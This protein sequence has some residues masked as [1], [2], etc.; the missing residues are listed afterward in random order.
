M[1]KSTFFVLISV[2]LLTLFPQMSIATPNNHTPYELKAM[3]INP[4]E[5]HPYGSA[6]LT[7]KIEGLPRGG[8][9]EYWYVVIEKKIKA[10]GEWK[11]SDE[12][13]SHMMLD[14]YQTSAG[15][16]EFE[17]IW[18]EDYAWDA[19]TPVSFRVKVALYDETYSLISE[20][21]YSNVASIGLQGSGW[22]MPELEKAN[23]YGLIPDILQGTDMTKPITREEFCELALL[24][25]E[26]STGKTPVPVSPNPFTDTQNP[27]I[28]KAF[29]L[30]ITQGTSKTT[31]SPDNTITRQECATML[32]RTI[33]AIAPNADYSVTGVPDFPD[34]KEI[35]SWAIEG[36]KYMSKLGIIK[37]DDRGYFMPKATTTAQQAAG[38]GTATREAAVLMSV[39]TYDAV[40]SITAGSP[41]ASNPS[42]SADR[43]SVSEEYCLAALPGGTV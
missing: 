1:K 14:Y 7:F 31:F 42:V 9:T 35:G 27:Q 17:Q 12:L 10:S 6:L 33:K 28:M 18:V 21:S 16:Y 25:Y 19:G 13:I 4:D 39:R 20:S 5:T 24:L 32:F 3:L 37:G 22:A 43:L 11:S 38:Y 2:L 23:G 29:A 30:G 34:Q 15:I 26:K 40:P 8:D 41:S 36:T